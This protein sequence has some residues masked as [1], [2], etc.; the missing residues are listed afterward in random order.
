M[1][2]HF[3][4]MHGLG[5]DFIII[6]DLESALN[7]SVAHVQWLCDR[8]RGIGAD[9]IMLVRPALSSSADYSWWFANADGTIPE[10]CGNGIRC[11]VR[12]L[13]DNGLVSQG[14]AEV[15]VDTAR[16]PLATHVL[17]KDSAVEGVRVHMGYAELTPSLI[18][19][20][21]NPTT[22][23]EIDGSK[24]DAV[25]DG[26]IPVPSSF[27]LGTESI[28]V[29][30]VSMGNPHAVIIADN[31]GWTI[32]NAPVNTL[33]AYLETH[34]V[35]SAKTNVEFITVHSEDHISMRV[36][37][38][39]CGE[40]QA[41][42]TGACAAVVACYLKGLT[43]SQVRV[44][45]LGGDLDIE[46]NEESLQVLMTGPASVAFHGEATLGD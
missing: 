10:M 38:R 13:V 16:G 15:T 37:E 19:T 35:F 42:G 5:N 4:K 1:N 30:M 32:N 41:C 27:D 44:T 21:L 23:I 29:T 7:L 46:I 12:Y 9:G 8:H 17:Y 36:W 45:L 2:L 33:G 20:T 31:Y 25:V 6:E 34:P 3:T 14:Q 40:T 43:S 24:F 39:G 22:M 11:F 26:S 28:A 18:P